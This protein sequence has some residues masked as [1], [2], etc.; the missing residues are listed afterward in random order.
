MINLLI[1]FIFAAIIV[2]Y[3]VG[4]LKEKLPATAT[5]YV[6]PNLLSLI[7]GVLVAFAFTL[8][9]FSAFGF[10]TEWVWIAYLLTGIL[11][12]G[13]SKLWHELISKLRESRSSFGE[14]EENISFSIKENAEKVSEER[15]KS[16]K[17][18]GDP[19]KSKD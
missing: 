13:G 6:D 14:P 5:K 12:A 4:V 3:V 11:I 1:G 8:D 17:T 15:I 9:V 19:A 2:E 18:R 16:I 7:I 10:T